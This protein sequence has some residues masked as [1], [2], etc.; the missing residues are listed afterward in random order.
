MGYT[1]PIKPTYWT[2]PPVIPIYDPPT[3]LPEEPEPTTTDTDIPTLPPPREYQSLTG[4]QLAG[5]YGENWWEAPELAQ[6][7]GGLTGGAV[8]FSD[9]GA[10]GGIPV[11]RGY[12]D[13]NGTWVPESIVPG[14]YDLY[15]SQPQSPE[16]ITQD[17]TGMG[18][19]PLTES[20]PYQDL[21]S[22][23]A[24]M[25]SPEYQQNVAQQ[26]QDYISNFLGTDWQT[27]T[28]ELDQAIA[29]KFAEIEQMEMY[30]QMSP[31]AERQLARDI[32]SVR[33]ENMEL[34]DALAGGGRGMSIWGVLD[35][36]QGQ[37][38]DATTQARF[39][40][41][42][43]Y[44]AKKELEYNALNDRY[45]FMVGAG[46]EAAGQYLGEIQNQR[47][48][49]MQGYMTQ[50]NATISANEQYMNIYQNSI[51]QVYQHF[52]MELGL[53][54]HEMNAASEA[55]AQYMTPYWEK[56]DILLAEQNLEL[57]AEQVAELAEPKKG[58]FGR[59]F[60]WLFGG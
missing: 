1:D 46:M 52:M 20:Q 39:A 3:A 13:E 17:L 41:S 24:Q 60:D 47:L 23:I 48:M 25:Q 18:W 12:Y 57:L 10:Y 50:M 37:I 2:P 7:T 11:I 4:S 49:T 44:L 19:T 14:A 32:Q 42:T 56:L 6:F 9:W 38:L 51:N 16:E 33:S 26:T 36:M 43:N 30:G 8:D 59:I 40:Y 45:K 53:D 35:S 58:L 34:A 22:M 5:I 31:E 15:Q 29:R 54:E 55:Y 21:S 27:K 28:T